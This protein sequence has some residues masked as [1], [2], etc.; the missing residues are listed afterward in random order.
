MLTVTKNKQLLIMLIC[1]EPT[2][3]ADFIAATSVFI[4][5]VVTGE[6]ELPI[7]IHKSVN[8]LSKGSI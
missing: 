5:L 3:D 6:T 4:K 1:D 7:D 8:L 2:Q